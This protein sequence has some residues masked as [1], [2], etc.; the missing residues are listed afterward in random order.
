MPQ[1]AK[2]DAGDEM[3]SGVHDIITPA[4]AAVILR[5]DVK[6]LYELVRRGVP[7]AKRLGPKAIRI[8]RAAMMKWFETETANDQPRK[9]R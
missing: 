6:T 7:W 2:R 5:V 8:S 9:R 1:A 3:P 4:E